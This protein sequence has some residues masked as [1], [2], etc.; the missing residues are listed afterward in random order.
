M[1][2]KIDND[3]VIYT[4]KK[5]KLH[6]ARVLHGTA[7]THM[8]ISDMNN[9]KLFCQF[10]GVIAWHKVVNISNNTNSILFEKMICILLNLGFVVISNMPHDN[11][12][13]TIMRMINDG[14]IEACPLYNLN[15]VWEYRW[16]G[17]GNL[18]LLE[19][20]PLFEGQ[21]AFEGV[22]N[23]FDLNESFD[24]LFKEHK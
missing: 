8:I 23:H 17:R 12:I 6:Y 3:T 4:G 7:L 19:A 2:I 18:P 24:E 13:K 14:N 22:D 15:I 11:S 10:V 5:Y 1:I 21:D 9:K 20:Y 16:S